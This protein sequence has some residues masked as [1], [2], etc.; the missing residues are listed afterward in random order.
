VPNS[1][2]VFP[3]G[4]AISRTVYA[5]LFGMLST[6]Y[7]A[8]LTTFNL[9]DLRG[10]VTAC[11]DNMGGSDATRLSLGALA[12]IR[13]S[14]GGAGGEA[15]HTQSI[16]EMPVHT[17][18]NVFS[19]PGHSH[20]LNAI[21]AYPPA[22]PTGIGNTTTQNAAAFQTI[23]TSTV[24]TGITYSNASQ[25]GGAAFNIMQPTILCNRIMRII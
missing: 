3:C 9:P 8:G 10:R 12:S 4:Q 1:S 5:A 20:T 25:G 6:A 13:F 17:H 2:F 23:G 16:A 22:N 21:V 19:D 14:L 11:V 18:P 24:G 15:A 7:G